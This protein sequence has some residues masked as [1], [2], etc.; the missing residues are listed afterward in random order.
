MRHAVMFLIAHNDKNILPWHSA[1]KKGG[2]RRYL[3]PLS[4]MQKTGHTIHKEEGGRDVK[5]FSAS[6][7]DEQ[8]QIALIRLAIDELRQQGELEW[9]PETSTLIK[10]TVSESRDQIL[11]WVKWPSFNVR[12]VM[13]SSEAG[14]KAFL[15]IDFAGTRRSYEMEAADRQAFLAFVAGLG[16]PTAPVVQEE[17]SDARQAAD[18]FIQAGEL[19]LTHLS[20]FL[21]KRPA[22]SVEMAFMKVVINGVSVNLPPPSPIPGDQG[23]FVPVGFYPSGE[24]ITIGW[25]FETRYVHA[26][27]TVLVGV[28]RNQSLQNR[29]LLATL[30]VE[31]FERYADVSNV[32]V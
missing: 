21:G 32:K 24:T 11:C 30:N 20:L 10:I 5:T 26:P 14:G 13:S 23:T 2:Y 28:F 22:A 19:G 27:A 7:K 6:V 9:P 3:A 15:H 31:M 8:G 18:D 12:C 16:L 29:T 17:E 1:D 4:T 25:E